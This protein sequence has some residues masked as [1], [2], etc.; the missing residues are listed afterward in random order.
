MNVADTHKRK[1]SAFSGG[2]TAIKD[3]VPE[4]VFSVF[5][6]IFFALLAFLMMAP[7]MHLVSKSVSREGEVLRGQVGLLPNFA[8]LQFESYG[9]VFQNDLF[10]HSFF[11][12]I[13]VTLIG[14]FVGLAVT[15]AA[16]YTL[17]KPYVRGR[18]FMLMLCIFIMLFH[19]GLIPTYLVI[20]G[21]G[22]TNT[23]TILWLTSIF[24][25]FNMLIIKNFYETVPIEM[26]ESARIDGA[27][28]FR[29]F[30]L[31][32]APTSKAVYAVISLF[33][34]VTL[35]NNFFTA[36]VYTTRRDLMTLQ[37]LLMNIIHQASDVFRDLH[38]DFE[39]MSEV[40][41]H[42]VIAA[43]VVVSTVPILLVYPFLQ[44]HFTKGVF[45]GSVKG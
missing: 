20:N 12:T 5:N 26:E 37:L 2:S 35:W 23:F 21:L 8:G 44:R 18:M 29:I 39:M 3:T 38:P 31:I 14:T 27:G 24:S 42:S 7:M 13:K 4:R 45:L 36:M 15:A 33:T 43:S 16:A 22:L 30:A 17:S 9:M 11:L 28:Q 32:Y 34:A 41:S 1:I 10:W 25:V 19:G 40:T 6:Y